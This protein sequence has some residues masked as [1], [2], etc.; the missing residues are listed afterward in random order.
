[1]YY[2][3]GLIALF[4]VYTITTQFGAIYVNVTNGLGRIKLQMFTAIIGAVLNIPLSIFF[5]KYMGMG[6][7][8]IKLATLICCLGSIVIIPIDITLFLNKKSIVAEK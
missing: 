4:A 7:S 5:A 1:M 2:E 3:P 8:G 6:I